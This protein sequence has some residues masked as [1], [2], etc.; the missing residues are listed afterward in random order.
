[1]AERGGWPA[2]C[3]WIIPALL[4]VWLLLQL[5]FT[6]LISLDRPLPQK[7][8][9]NL[10]R[11]LNPLLPVLLAPMVFGPRKAFSSGKTLTP[12]TLELLRVATASPVRSLLCDSPYVRDGWREATETIN[13]RTQPSDVVLVRPHHHA[14]RHNELDRLDWSTVPHWRSAE[15][16]D[17]FFSDEVR[18]GISDCGSLCTMIVS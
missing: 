8:S 13:A 15:E 11:F 9:I 5:L 18:P 2:H 16:S 17:E 14:P 6:F 7:R 3:R 1:M 12:T 4:T 10:D